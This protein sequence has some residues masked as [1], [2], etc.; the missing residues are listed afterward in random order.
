MQTAKQ[1]FK[2]FWFPAVI[3][4]GWTIY[5]CSGAGNTTGNLADIKKYVNI[6]GPTFFLISWMTG[7]LFRVKKQSKVESNLTEIENRVGSLLKELELKAERI[8]NHITGGDSYFFAKLICALP[9]GDK[10]TVFMLENNYCS[11]V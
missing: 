11:G 9:M 10:G 6:F 4:I 7:Q 8:T 1:L 3:A 5:S 2:E